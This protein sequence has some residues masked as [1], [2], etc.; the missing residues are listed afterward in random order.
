MSSPHLIC[1]FN[2]QIRCRLNIPPFLEVSE[3][4]WCEELRTNV[5]DKAEILKQ[6]HYGKTVMVWTRGGGSEIRVYEEIP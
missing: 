1:Y 6:E 2:A 5:I 3:T 4:P